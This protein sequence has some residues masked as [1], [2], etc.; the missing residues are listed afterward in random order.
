MDDQFDTI[1]ASLTRPPVFPLRKGEIDEI[2]Q[3]ADIRFPVNQRQGRLLRCVNPCQTAPKALLIHGW[4]GNP[5]MLKLQ[6]DLLQ[7]LGYRISMPFLLGHDP[8]HPESCSIPEQVH[9]LMQLQERE[10]VFDL[11]IAHSAGGLITALAA[12]LGFKVANIIL[13]SSPSSFPELLERKLK[14]FSTASHHRIALHHHYLNDASAGPELMSRKVFSGLQASSLV[15]HG[16][17]D[18]KI[19]VQDALSL[20]QQLPESELVLVNGTG[21][22]G[23]LNH[24]M[25]LQAITD[26]LCR[27]ASGT[28]GVKRNAWPY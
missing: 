10:G 23:I 11:V 22:L 25:T 28:K 5:F 21:H 9:L 27:P 24:K 3:M 4:G 13:I 2:R 7:H 6:K 17:A 1:L 8:S 16:S 18:R 26:Y 15:I 19:D 20:H 14:D 12:T